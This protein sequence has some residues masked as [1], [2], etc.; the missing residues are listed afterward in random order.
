MK[1]NTQRSMLLTLAGLGL[2]VGIRMMV[3]E[4]RR[5]DLRGRVAIVTG[6]SRGLG[7]VLA[8]QL[9]QEGVRLVICSRTAHQLD[10]AAREL[11]DLGAD[12]LAV[13]CDVTDRLQVHAL[14]ERTI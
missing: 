2:M 11:R 8:R 1:A 6:G 10:A 14:I 5:Y 9:A 12:V 3:A 4:R 7:L 13:P